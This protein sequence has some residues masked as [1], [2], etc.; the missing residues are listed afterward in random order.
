MSQ[1]TKHAV[2]LL[3]LLSLSGLGLATPSEALQDPLNAQVRFALPPTVKTVGDAYRFFLAPYAY[4][5]TTSPPASPAARAGFHGLLPVPLPHDQVMTV[6]R[7]L[8][9][10]TP[11]AWVIVIDH[12]NKLVSLDPRTEE[13]E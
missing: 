3:V 4:R 13:A 8:L 1:R 6:K 7:A 5:L 10:V 9:E 12:P 11:E 2:R